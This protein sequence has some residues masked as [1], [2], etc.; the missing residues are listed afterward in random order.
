MLQRLHGNVNQVS[1]TSVRCFLYQ[2]FFINNR[3][4]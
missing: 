3:A 4:T 2:M 1:V